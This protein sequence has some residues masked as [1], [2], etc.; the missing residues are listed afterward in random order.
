MKELSEIT[1]A[2][3]KTDVVE[4]VQTQTQGRQFEDLCQKMDELNKNS[5]EKLEENKQAT[6]EW[7]NLFK[8]NMDT[9]VSKIS[10]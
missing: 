5:I 10:C 6:K 9:L 1:N 8:S 2:L 7:S 4:V 3:K